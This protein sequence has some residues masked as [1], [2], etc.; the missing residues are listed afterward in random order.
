MASFWDLLPAAAAGQ[1]FAAAMPDQVDPWLQFL[2][3]ATQ[4]ATGNNAASPAATSANQLG[5]TF[6]AA[7]AMQPPASFWDLLPAT[8]HGQPFVPVVPTPD[9]LDH[10]FPPLGAARPVT[11]GAQVFF[12]GADQASD[13]RGILGLLPPAVAPAV[14][15]ASEGAIASRLAMAPVGATGALATAILLAMTEPLG[16]STRKLSQSDDPL[17]QPQYVLRGGLRSPRTCA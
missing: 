3:A 14:G 5:D 11:P 17:Y 4:A 7:A 10:Y 9:Q 6:G 8:P 15:E 2:P 13:S 16:D 1:P 12:P